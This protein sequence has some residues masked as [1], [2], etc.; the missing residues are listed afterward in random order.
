MDDGLQRVL[1]VT[2]RNVPDI[3]VG[4]ERDSV[5][6]RSMLMD[7]MHGRALFRAL[8]GATRS[9]LSPPAPR[10]MVSIIFWTQRIK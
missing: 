1:H 8:Q 5:Q 7:P 4:K 3:S 9:R 2:C 6:P 10:V